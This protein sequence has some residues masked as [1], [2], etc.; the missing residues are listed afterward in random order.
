MN[1]SKYDR[2]WAYI[3]AL[4][5]GETWEFRPCEMDGHTPR[6]FAKIINQ[7]YNRRTASTGVVRTHTTSRG[8]MFVRV[9]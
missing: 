8:V 4:D 1:R 2:L 6:Q 5:V 9:E 3:D 7:R